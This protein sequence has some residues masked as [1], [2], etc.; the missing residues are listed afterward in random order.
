[1]QEIVNVL[2]TWF[3][4]PPAELEQVIYDTG[5]EKKGLTVLLG[6]DVDA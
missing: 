3:E 1:M 2:E 4:P 5:L 6:G